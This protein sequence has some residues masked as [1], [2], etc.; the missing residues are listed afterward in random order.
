LMRPLMSGDSNRVVVGLRK[1][2][3]SSE[4]GSPSSAHITSEKAATSAE[5][6]FVVYSK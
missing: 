5:Q 4:I 6:D 1:S 3:E 2:L